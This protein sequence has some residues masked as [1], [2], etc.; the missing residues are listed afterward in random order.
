MA[1]KTP[2]KRPGEWEDIDGESAEDKN[3]RWKQFNKDVDKY[4]AENTDVGRRSGSESDDDYASAAAQHTPLNP[5]AAQQHTPLNP[6][7]AQAAQPVQAADQAMQ[8]AVVVFAP[9]GAMA[10]GGGG[11]VPAGGG[12]MHPAAGGLLKAL[13]VLQYQ[14]VFPYPPIP[15]CVVLSIC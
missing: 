2:H 6:Q 5:Q 7:P 1:E 15:L 4:E 8:D 9:V 13:I 11:G 10:A 14:C 12:P 3:K